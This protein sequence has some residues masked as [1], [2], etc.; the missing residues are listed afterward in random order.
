[1][2]LIANGLNGRYFAELLK[3]AEQC[4]DLEHIRV[5]AA[6]VNKSRPLIDLAK[7][8]KVPLSIY[9][10]L[11]G[12]KWP[13]IAELE[14]FVGLAPPSVQLFVT[15]NFYHPKIYWFEGVGAYIG[16]ANLTDGGWMKNIECGVWLDAN[17]IEEQGLEAELRTMFSSIAERCVLA[18]K[19]HVE[20]VKELRHERAE[21]DRARRSFQEAAAKALAALPGQHAI[22]D[23][24]KRDDNGGA[25]K[26]AF[27]DEWFETLG[28]LRKLV[29][30]AK[31]RPNP[32]WV[33][34]DAHPAIVQDQATEL[35]YD[36]N[37]R[38]VG[39]DQ[40]EILHRHNRGRTDAAIDEVFEGWAALDESD[41]ENWAGWVNDSPRLLFD[42]LSRASLRTLDTTKLATI[43]YNSHA[44]RAHARQM[45]NDELGL[46][47]GAETEMEE[48]CRVYAHYLMEKKT[49]EG[50][51]GVAEILDYVIWADE[52]ESNCAE[53]L[54]N[55][56][57]DPAWRLPHLGVHTLSELLG[58]A[59]PDE[60]P[61]RNHRVRKTL[62]A[63]GFEQVRM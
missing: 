2:E 37:I 34:R 49:D 18:T 44:F 3:L 29:R 55:A 48:R 61:P 50:K 4:D 42:L 63:L 24:T 10:L 14:Y 27:V 58:Y 25:A 8:K 12:D 6:Y 19:E 9:A 39:Q 36:I 35:W 52:T 23:Q 5:A 11:D 45:R 26:R 33:D 17:D 51:R 60:F 46:P 28:V 59:R 57:Q 1:V 16:S 47:S 41:A 15:A 13:P 43:I 53:R 40:I 56:T 32:T 31:E 54:W 20:L 7:R 30:I 62:R 38:K 21:F 22:I